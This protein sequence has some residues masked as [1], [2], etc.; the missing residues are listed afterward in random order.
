M[1]LSMHFNTLSRF[2]IAFL[3]RRKCLLISLLQSLSAVIFEPKKIKFVTVSAFS[4]SIGC[5]VTGLGAIAL[6]FTSTDN[7]LLHLLE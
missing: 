4:L 7:M 3:P 1:V 6:F 2:V 5:E